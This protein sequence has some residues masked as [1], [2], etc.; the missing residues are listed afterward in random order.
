MSRRAVGLVLIIVGLLFG[1]VPLGMIEYESLTGRQRLDAHLTRLAAQDRAEQARTREAAAQFNAAFEQTGRAARDPFESDLDPTD[2]EFAVAGEQFAH[3]VIPSIDVSLPLYLGASKQH[4][5]VG[6]GQVEGT[7]LPVGG[8]GTRSVV[9]GHRGGFTNHFFLFV[10]QLEPGDRIYVIV[11]GEL[12]VYEVYGSEVIL[13]SEWERLAAV[14]GQDTLTLLTCTPPPVNSHRLLVDARRVLP[15]AGEA[16][17]GNLDQLRSD[18]QQAELAP[19]ASGARMWMWVSRVA[20]VVLMIGLVWT[21]VRLARLPWGA[22]RD[23]PVG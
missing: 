21:V 17:A 20:L 3:L 19:T 14:D 18:L 5:G 12:L 8:V 23:R 13:P 11:Q 7:S 16:A 4:L 15:P 10:D 1:L 22:D 2:S 9:A 6:L